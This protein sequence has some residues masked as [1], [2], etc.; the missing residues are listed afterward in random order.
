MAHEIYDG[1]V[2]SFR[3]PM[4]HHLGEVIEK[5]L[6]ATQ[7][8][9]HIGKYRVD[10][11]PVR[12]DNGTDTGQ[13][14]I[15]RDYGEP[16]QYVF[17]M[18]KGDYNLVTPEDICDAWDASVTRH[19]ETMGALREGSV[20]FVSTA[21]GSRDIRGDEIKEYLLLTSPMSGMEAISALATSVRT[22]CM[23]TLIAA[24]SAARLTF[25]IPHNKFAK[26]RTKQWLEYLIARSE[27]QFEKQRDAYERF[28]MH[29]P[30]EAQ[31]AQVLEETY[32]LPSGEIRGIVDEHTRAQREKWNEE[33]RRAA[34]GARDRTRDLF[35]GKG[36]GMDVEA[37]R[38]TFWG[39]YNAVTEDRDW[40]NLR[41]KKLEARARDTLFGV[42]ANEK[43]RAYVTIDRLIT[44]G[45]TRKVRVRGP[46]GTFVKQDA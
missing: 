16:N 21:L 46:K 39:L 19:I 7:A 34:L 2:V 20:F 12:L 6:T 25:Q 36:T 38:G 33:Y 11:V 4:W 37:A 5:E 30:T 17:G 32:P 3:Q 43:E 8:Y 35:E 9:D 45:E 40:G 31:V 10:L 42:R 27:S 29:S 13:R 41:L 22:V 24:R 1:K 28:A 23:N 44:T 18:V 14:A 15:V 26:E